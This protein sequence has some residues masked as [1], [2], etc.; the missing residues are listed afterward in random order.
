VKLFHYLR[1]NFAGEESAKRRHPGRIVDFENASALDG[2]WVNAFGS[3]ER[4]D[5]TDNCPA[6]KDRLSAD[7]AKVNGQFTHLV[8]RWAYTATYCKPGYYPRIEMS[9]KSEHYGRRYT[10]LDSCD[11]IDSG[12]DWLF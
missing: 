7:K 9:N 12:M 4:V 1:I 8:N 11:I 3:Q 2:A 6:F 5:A 10:H